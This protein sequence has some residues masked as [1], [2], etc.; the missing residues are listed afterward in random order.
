M[1][2]GTVVVP[3]H[4][5]PLAYCVCIG[6][7][8]LVCLFLAV[9]LHYDTVVQTHC[10]NW[11]YWPSVSSCTGDHMP[12]RAVWRIAIALG[13]GPRIIAA[14]LQRMH[15]NDHLQSTRRCD[16]TTGFYFD[17]IRIVAAGMW[18]YV[19]SSEH[20]LVHEV[21]FVLYVVAGFVAQ[22]AQTSA[23]F[24]VSRLPSAASERLRWSFRAKAFLFGGQVLFACGVGYFFVEHRTYCLPG[25]YSK[26]T[27]CEW[28]FSACNVLYDLTCMHDLR[29]MAF[30]V[31]ARSSQTAAA[32]DTVT[33]PAGLPAL[34]KA[35]LVA[36]VL[37]GYLYWT[38]MHVLPL[39]VYF[40]PM[41]R[42]AFTAHPAVIFLPGGMAAVLCAAGRFRPSRKTAAVL[43]FASSV[44]L[45]SF[46]IKRW[47]EAKLCF[48]AFGATLAT[49]AVFL[50]MTEPG[51]AA[52]PIR[53]R[54]QWGFVCGL[55]VHSVVRMAASGQD[56]AVVSGAFNGLVVLATAVSAAVLFT[57]E[58][59]RPAAATVAPADAKRDVSG[60]WAGVA[61]GTFT[62]LAHQ[63]CSE[64]GVASRWVG[65][66]TLPYGMA[67]VVCFAVGTAA[68]GLPAMQTATRQFSTVCAVGVGAAVLAVC[69]SGASNRMVEVDGKWPLVAPFPHGYYGSPHLS[70]LGAGV[71][72]PA[73][74]GLHARGILSRALDVPVAAS[75]APSAP[76]RSQLRTT[77]AASL[78]TWAA[79]V[80]ASIYV[81]AF[82]FVPGGSLLRDRV[83]V[84]VVGSALLLGYSTHRT[85]AQKVSGQ[86]L[87]DRR[88]NVCWLVLCL[89]ALAA[90]STFRVAWQSTND[91]EL[92]K[93]QTDR[94]KAAI[95]TIHYGYDEWGND[96]YAGLV[97][98]LNASGANVIG[99][100]E[101]DI[102]RIPSGNRDFVEYASDR[103]GMYSDFGPPTLD[104]TFGCA[105]LSKFPFV[106]VTRYVLPS[107][108][109]ELACMIH[110][111]VDTGASGKVNVY[112]SHFGN[113]EHPIDRKL[114]SH[115]LAELA[116]TYPGPSVFLGYL[117]TRPGGEQYKIIVN[118]ETGW[119]DTGR[120]I[121]YVP[122]TAAG[123][124]GEVYFPKAQ[125]KMKKDPTDPSVFSGRYCEY[126][127]Y[128]GLSMYWWDMT[129]FKL[130]DTELQVVYFDLTKN[131]PAS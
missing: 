27:L 71:L 14:V 117:T 110:A 118:N 33:P 24:R 88:R 80:I 111:V 43:L 64:H 69:G 76:A 82:T 95:W 22:G 28:C 1:A 83:W 46:D 47:P 93:Y 115:S 105:V 70:F 32:P 6:S 50:R 12:E 101:T 116:K 107:P 127:L 29:G 123:L 100:L 4:L 35:G 39:H 5:F 120:D 37:S 131:V 77:I 63:L 128:R 89:L 81:V 7:G 9:R 51:P 42:M 21:A 34:Q 59:W 26:S 92:S 65:L 62:F 61:L 52:A 40:L 38:Y 87:D 16:V 113:T 18:T 103:L 112:V 25:G 91:E 98:E 3:A 74:I 44:G 102:S 45:H 36:D 57:E 11:E 48:A 109:G 8:L 58:Q 75:D 56:P 79:L 2:S 72:L 99:L 97:R 126:I 30:S 108:Q 129:M 125:R 106:S 73:C 122:H 67:P 121:R 10:R 15:F 41:V 104:D 130:S 68:G 114:Q 85:I 49:A 55:S 19:S 31:V 86:P 94:L 17:L 90:V 96:N 54:A 119:R 20:L 60:A 13:G 66:P 84:L 78:L 23:A 124:N 53:E